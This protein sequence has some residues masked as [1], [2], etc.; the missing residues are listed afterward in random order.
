M[1]NAEADL[2]F[3][4]KRSELFDDLIVN[5]DIDSVVGQLGGLVLERVKA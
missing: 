2:E 3:F 4:A 5:D 1:K